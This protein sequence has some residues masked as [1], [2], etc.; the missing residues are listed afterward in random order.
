[1]ESEFD[2]SDTE[3][4]DEDEIRTLKYNNSLPYSNNAQHH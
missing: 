3:E 4:S 1:M 2:E